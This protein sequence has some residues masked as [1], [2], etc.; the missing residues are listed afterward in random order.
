MKKCTDCKFALLKDYGYSNYTVEGTEFNCLKNLNPSSGIDIWY[1]EA[2]ELLFAEQC[3]SFSEGDPFRLSVE[4]N[5]E[6]YSY[7][8]GID[9]EEVTAFNNYFNFEGNNK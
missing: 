5:L 1:N 6:P 7:D 9:E 4:D 2:P 8:C 3:N